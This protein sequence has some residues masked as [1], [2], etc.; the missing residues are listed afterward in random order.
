MHFFK[1]IH[2]LKNFQ[3]FEKEMFVNMTVLII[4]G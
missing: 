2:Y 1:E 3:S 4:L